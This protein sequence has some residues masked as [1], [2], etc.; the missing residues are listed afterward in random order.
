M[1]DIYKKGNVPIT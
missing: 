1:I